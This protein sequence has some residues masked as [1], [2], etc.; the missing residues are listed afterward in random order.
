MLRSLVFCYKINFV[1]ND[2][3]VVAR[4][5]PDDDA[6]GCLRLDALRHVD[7]QHH[8]VDDLRA[9]ND[10]SNERGVTGAID[11]SVL[12][13][14]EAQLLEV[15]GGVDAEGAEAEVESDAAFL[16]LWV[17]V[18]GGRAGDGAQGFGQ[19]GFA[20]VHVTQDAHVEVE[21]RGGHGVSLCQGEKCLPTLFTLFSVVT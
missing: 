14:V 21:S 3:H 9:A 8:Q 15:V 12:D 16:R 10:G 7:H 4:D 17:F 5:L 20:A 13:V 11:Q 19:A 6:L 1:K 18:E 2:D